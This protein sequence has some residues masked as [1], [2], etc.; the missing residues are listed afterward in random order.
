MSVPLP[1]TL[2]TK[3]PTGD[4]FKSNLMIVFG[5]KRTLNRYIVLK[6]STNENYSKQHFA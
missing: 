6:T 5:K 2:L 1:D 3:F 4:Y